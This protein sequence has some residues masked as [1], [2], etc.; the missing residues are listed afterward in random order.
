MSD[1][2]NELTE[3]EVVTLCKHRNARVFK[4]HEPRWHDKRV[5]LAAHKLRD[6]NVV[7][8][9][10]K[11]GSWAGL[12]YISGKNARKFPIQSNGVIAVKAVPLRDLKPFVW[13]LRCPH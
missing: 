6:F 10:E 3:Q 2:E 9:S 7:E 1:L 11:S 12:Y 5:L 8:L 13:D 4:I